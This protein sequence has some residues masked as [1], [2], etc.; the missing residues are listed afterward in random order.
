MTF[1]G[2]S[3]VTTE[4]DGSH[5][6]YSY[7]TNSVITLGN[8]T[9]LSTSGTDAYSIY[10]Y[11]GKITGTGKFT[12]GTVTKS[13]AIVARNAIVD[14]NM[15]NASY[16]NGYSNITGTGKI[17]I[18]MSQ[19]STWKLSQSSKLSSI[20]VASASTI[21]F[22]ID[23]QDDYRFITADE[24]VLNNSVIKVVL[25]SYNPVLND[26]F[27]LILSSDIS[28]SD[29]SFDFS[30]AILQNGLMWDTSTFLT[31]GTIRIIGAVPEPLAISAIFGLLALGAVRLRRKN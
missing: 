7:G 17:N 6:I 26:E 31:D 21:V 27:I 12:L 9:T 11:A 2:A 18:N 16:F 28:G 4:G 5:A 3:T 8:A 15:N 19:G 22:T 10:G 20:H 1:E 24:A 13:E 25:G 29:L 23:A 30:E 14:L